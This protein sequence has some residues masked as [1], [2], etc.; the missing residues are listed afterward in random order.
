MSW[1]SARSVSSRLASRDCL[2]RPNKASVL[3]GNYTA[4]CVLFFFFSGWCKMMFK[5]GLKMG[6]RCIFSLYKMSPL[7]PLHSYHMEP[8]TP[9]GKKRNVSFVCLSIFEYITPTSMLLF[10]DFL[11]LLSVL[12]CVSSLFCAADL[13]LSYMAFVISSYADDFD[14]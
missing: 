12:F 10:F 14:I 6:T 13:I 11:R 7:S 5:W 8:P 2:R 4:S 3:A 1:T 9:L